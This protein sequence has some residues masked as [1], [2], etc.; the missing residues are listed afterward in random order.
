MYAEVPGTSQRAQRAESLDLGQSDPMMV[1]FR[2]L[3]TSAL[4]P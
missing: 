1:L 3:R 4:G 2:E